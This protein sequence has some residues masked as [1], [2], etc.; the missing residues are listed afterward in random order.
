MY[1]EALVEAGDDP[2]LRSSIH[3]RLASVLFFTKGP[4]AAEPDAQTALRLAEDLDD[5]CALA[6]SLATVARVAFSLGRGVQLEL[7]TRAIALEQ[8]CPHLFFYD[9]PSVMFASQLNFVDEHE[10]SRERWRRLIEQARALEE[11]PYI[12]LYWWSLLE[13][14]AGDWSRAA[15]LAKECLSC[16]VEHGQEHWE[17]FGAHAFAMVEAHRGDQDR[18]RAHIDRCWRVAEAAG[19]PTFIVGCRELLGFL[20]LSVGDPREACKQLASGYEALAAMGVREPGRFFFLPD[21]LEALIALGETDEAE[22]WLRWLEERGRTLDRP[23]AL[24]AAGRCR[25]LFEAARGRND[26]AIEVLEAAL[27]EHARFEN[28]FELGKTLLVLGRARRRANRRKAARETLQNALQTF[29]T[30]GAALWAE[31]VRAEL[32]R[33]GGRAPSEGRLTPVEERVAALVAEGRTNREVAA[34]L[35]LSDRTVEGH[36]SRVYVKLG[37]RSRVEL[38]RALPHT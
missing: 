23:W 35:H 14:R 5:P 17:A 4:A 21:Y 10:R 12:P 28:P 22:R 19:Q 15:E 24:A 26:L 33:I 34:A 32:A 38:A 13:H 7:M 31:K 37:V 6:L 27:D 11:P 2:A 30:L 20:A 1:T 8:S 25:G 9:R 29:E 16:A 36:L 18:A 3:Q